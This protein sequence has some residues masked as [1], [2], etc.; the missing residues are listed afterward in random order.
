MM[1]TSAATRSNPAKTIRDFS[2]RSR[3]IDFG[4]RLGMDPCS[5]SDTP[6][7]GLK[8]S[9]GTPIERAVRATR[10]YLAGIGTAGALALGAALVFAAASAIIAF[11]GWPG[12]NTS[13]GPARQVVSVTPPPSGVARRLAHI[14]T[15][16][17]RPG[18]ARHQAPARAG[19]SHR[20]AVSGARARGHVRGHGVMGT[21]HGTGTT[22]PRTASPT[23]GRHVHQT[24]PHHHRSGGP[25]HSKSYPVGT[26]TPTS[27]APT[28]STPTSTAPT[29]TTAVTTAPATTPTTTTTPVKIRVGV[30]HGHTVT[31]TTIP[32]TTTATV[33]TGPITIR[34]RTSS[35]PPDPS[36]T[37]P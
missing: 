20:H 29:V 30:G 8:F 34:P 22:T 15:T 23:P 25:L 17:K 3:P 12:A 1:S 13:T 33:P 35:T 19:G 14:A 21:Q 24:R 36:T 31:I 4:G 5:Q 2:P 10:A 16:A 18:T 32:T 37:T 28:T 11:R 27:S 26:Q 9:P 7:I 6:P